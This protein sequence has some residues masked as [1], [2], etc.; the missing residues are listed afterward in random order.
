MLEEGGE[1]GVVSGGK[2]VIDG[3]CWGRERVWCTAAGKA[4]LHRSSQGRHLTQHTT[5]HPEHTR[6]T[7]HTRARLPPQVTCW[8]T[9]Q[10]YREF[11]HVDDLASACL[12]LMNTY[13]RWV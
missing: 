11:L 5:P 13:S 7:L 3:G 2:R 1:G 10:V 4:Q 6:N 8:G 12:F 9:G